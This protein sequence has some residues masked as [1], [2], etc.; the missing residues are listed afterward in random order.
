MPRSYS[1]NLGLTVE[2][3]SLV[4]LVYGI[5][6]NKYR[7]ML[8]SP[9][10]AITS[11]F[12]ALVLSSKAFSVNIIRQVINEGHCISEWGNDDDQNLAGNPY[13]WGQKEAVFRLRADIRD[14]YT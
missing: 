9:E 10:M 1:G 2:D 3:E 4:D 8:V 12:R 7:I 13:Q 5:G 6:E 14:T 11:K